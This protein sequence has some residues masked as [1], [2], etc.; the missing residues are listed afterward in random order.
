MRF[1]VDNQLPSALARFLDAEGWEALH[2]RDLAMAET[3]D[4]VIWDYAKNHDYTIVSKDEDF[5]YLSSMNVN[6]PALVWVRLGNCRREVLLGAF[7]NVLPQLIE[8]LQAG[9]KVVEIR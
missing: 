4:H 5:L 6:G 8:N 3:S 9:R 1:L 2:V 7:K